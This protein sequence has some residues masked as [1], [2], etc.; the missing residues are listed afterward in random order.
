MKNS[1]SSPN[2]Q[3][4]SD[5]GRRDFLSL[6]LLA[7]ST[8]LLSAESHAQTPLNQ[9][10]DLAIANTVTI[11]DS[12]ALYT[13]LLDD[14]RRSILQ[15]DVSMIRVAKFEAT[16]WLGQTTSKAE[17][18]RSL[19]SQGSTLTEQQ[20]GEISNF[21][22]DVDRGGNEISRGLIR[23]RQKPL[24]EIR[25]LDAEFDKIRAQLT[26]AS[27]ALKNR[28]PERAKAGVAAAI[29][30]LGKYSAGMA[31]N[32]SQPRTPESRPV[33]PEMQGPTRQQEPLRPQEPRQQPLDQTIITMPDA[34][35]LRALL[36]T[37]LE[38]LNTT[39]GSG[40][41]DAHHASASKYGAVFV[42]PALQSG[43]NAVLR[44]KLNP[45]SWLQVGIGYAVTFPILLRVSDKNNRRKLL[46]DAL[47][48]VPPGLRNPLLAELANDL[49]NL[50]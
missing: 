38:L 42:E 30:N 31:D 33:Q 29:A 40:P 41:S 20:K 15:Y 4:S 39:A 21:L 32:P 27:N 17:R 35:S 24:E 47:R 1:H 49:A 50:N 14:L 43:I 25:N 6:S 16:D 11:A 9:T 34:S 45:A 2:T 8:L 5:H 18:L 10:D 7:G 3:T 36:Q 19:L 46:N 28:N 23:M 44:S 12:I 37:V 22:F 26:A 13:N 48:L